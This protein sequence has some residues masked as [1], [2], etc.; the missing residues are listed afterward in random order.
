[1]TVRTVLLVKGTEDSKDIKDTRSVNSF[2]Y[3]FILIPPLRTP[4]YEMDVTS[5]TGIQQLEKGEK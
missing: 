3:I 5:L 1:M 2:A 4:E